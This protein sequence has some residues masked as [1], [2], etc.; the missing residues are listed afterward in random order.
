MLCPV[1]RVVSRECTGSYAVC[2]FTSSY[3]VNDIL[4]TMIVEERDLYVNSFVADQL[5]HGKRFLV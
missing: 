3:H 4:L 1:V 5:N 2:S